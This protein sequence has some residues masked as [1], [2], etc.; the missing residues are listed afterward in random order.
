MSGFGALAQNYDGFIVDLWGVVHDG[1]APYPGVLDC[2][3][4]LKEAGKR[5]VFL[6]NAP[7]RSAGITQFL[8]SMGVTPH[9]HDGVMSS[10][11]AVYLGLKNRTEEFATLG[12]RL[13]H[14]GPPRDRDV[15]DTLD[16]EEA[17]DPAVADF[18]LN[19][20]P[21]DNLGPHNADLY[22]PALDACL[23]ARLPM[24]CANPDLE[25]MKG[26]D[27]IICAGYLA[28]LYEGDGGTVIQRGKPDAAIYKP[29][30]ALLGTSAART[31]AVGDSLR[32][33]ITGAKAA[34][35]DSCWVLSGIHALHPEQAPA[36]AEASGLNPTAI[37][38]GFAW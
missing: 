17:A 26:G 34:G 12:K 8:A 7:R 25:V 18:V 36:E 38:P 2:L 15:F 22:R 37:L 3:K 24:I 13:Y 9:L 10:G 30:L 5:V 19:T 31:M 27:R 32:T 6:S 16:Y 20:G 35:I 23:K 11:E 4:R 21:D 29:T 14:L 28:Q 33:D 1:F